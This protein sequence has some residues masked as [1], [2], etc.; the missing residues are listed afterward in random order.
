M[1]YT[2]F[3]YLYMQMVCALLCRGA[4]ISDRLP[5]KRKQRRCFS[6]VDCVAKYPI[7]L[8]HSKQKKWKA[9]KLY[10]KIL[11]RS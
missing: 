9:D 4:I 1:F 8:R 3:L 11:A 10:I 5:G 2:V 7:Y 6:V